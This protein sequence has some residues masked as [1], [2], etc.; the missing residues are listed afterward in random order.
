MSTIRLSET[1]H[2]AIPEDL[3]AARSWRPGQEL[4][5]VDAGEGILIRPLSAFLPTRLDDV[6]G[7]LAYEGPPVSVEEM[8]GAVALMRGADAERPHDRP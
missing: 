7:C 8:N 1:G 6:A 5:V 2:V 4:E 3:R